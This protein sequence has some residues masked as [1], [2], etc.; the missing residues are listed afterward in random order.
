MSSLMAW[1]YYPSLEGRTASTPR[2][3]G[4]AD[5]DC[6]TLLYQREGARPRCR[7]CWV[8]RLP[9]TGGVI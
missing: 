2:L 6:L 9:C 8:S 4:H 1:N 3:F 5:M 7:A